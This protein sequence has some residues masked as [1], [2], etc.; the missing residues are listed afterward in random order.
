LANIKNLGERNIHLLD[1]L[2]AGGPYDIRGF[3]L[4][5]IGIRTENCSLGGEASIVSR[6]QLD[7]FKLQTYS[8]VPVPIHPTQSISLITLTKKTKKNKIT[9]FGG[10]SNSGDSFASLCTINSDRYG[11]LYNFFDNHFPFT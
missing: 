8:P 3:E 1:R 9:I 2:Y 5:S 11:K 6:F 4:N 10:N 7:L